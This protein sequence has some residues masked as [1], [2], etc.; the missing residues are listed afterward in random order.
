[1]ARYELQLQY[2]MVDGKEHTVMLRSSVTPPEALF[3]AVVFKQQVMGIP[4]ESIAN[5]NCT[6]AKT[7]MYDRNRIGYAEGVR[8][9]AENYLAMMESY[10]LAASKR[11]QMTEREMVTAFQECRAIILSPSTLPLQVPEGAIVRNP[12]F[13][14]GLS[15]FCLN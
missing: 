8:P 7:I 9:R 6:T 12:V 13:E 3:N 14:I 5:D 2:K 4:L 15:E 10:I 1:M 11:L